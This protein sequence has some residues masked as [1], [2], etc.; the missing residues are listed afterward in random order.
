MP[1]PSRAGSRYSEMPSIS[2]SA[3][4]SFISITIFMANKAHFIY[5]IA[6]AR[7]SLVTE[8]FV[9]SLFTLHQ[10]FTI[11]FTTT[12]IVIINATLATTATS[13]RRKSSGRQRS[14]TYRRLPEA[15]HIH[16]GGAARARSRL[17]QPPYSSG[18]LCSL[19]G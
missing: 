14:L 19:S 3:V 5:N 7:C 12:I 15:H 18:D 13:T 8:L 17:H 6:T 2:R 9:D 1:Q 10:G 16:Q 11:P 4:S